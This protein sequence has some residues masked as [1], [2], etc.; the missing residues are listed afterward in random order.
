MLIDSSQ[1]AMRIGKLS[2]N[3]KGRCAGVNYSGMNSSPIN[4]LS[5]KQNAS[6]VN[7]HT[8]SQTLPPQL[9]NF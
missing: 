9:L 7:S 2:L 3:P 8:S 4:L 6:S 5:Y 1:G